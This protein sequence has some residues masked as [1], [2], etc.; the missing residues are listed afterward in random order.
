MTSVR[1]RAATAPATLYHHFPDG[2]ASLLTSA[3]TR[4]LE[5]YRAAMVDAL[6]T[7]AADLDA[8]V[9]AIVRAHVGW[10]LAAP[11]DAALLFVPVPRDVREAS[12]G[13]ASPD[14]LGHLAGVLATIGAAD[15]PDAVPWDQ[16]YAIVLGP[17]QE[18]GRAWLGGRS[19]VPD[20]A[21]V[22]RLAA[23]AVAGAR[24][25]RE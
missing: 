19:P 8:V 4:A 17:A 15:L 13:Q 21:T 24:A 7:G 2:L 16:L 23:A 25:L 14:L 9:E 18:H 11:S 3:R 10:M 22:D 12:D 5:R 20:A 1:T 6:G